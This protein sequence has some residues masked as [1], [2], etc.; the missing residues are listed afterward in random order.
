MRTDTSHKSSKIIVALKS[1]I[2]GSP[3]CQ[4]E[5]VWAT[6]LYTPDSGNATGRHERRA[7]ERIGATSQPA[8]WIMCQA[9]MDNFF[10]AVV[11][12]V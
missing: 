4:V 11:L 2:V 1:T 7:V 5:F 12:R 9:L 3:E 10:H 6:A 8:R